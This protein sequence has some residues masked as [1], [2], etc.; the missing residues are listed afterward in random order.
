[1]AISDADGS[2]VFGG[3]AAGPA[4]GAGEGLLRRLPAAIRDGLTAEQQEAIRRAAGEQPW[5]GHGVN[6]RLSLPLPGRRFYLTI[7]GGP[8]RR[9]APRLASERADHPLRTFANSFFV[10][11]VALFFYGLILAA[12]FLHAA[13]IEF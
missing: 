8:E 7:V 10:A 5:H 12:I 3:A 13:I 1:M 6:I 11:A 4:G 9:P 2:L